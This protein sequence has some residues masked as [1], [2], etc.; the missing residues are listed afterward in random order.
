MNVF[1]GSLFEPKNNGTWESTINRD[2]AHYNI[3]HCKREEDGMAALREIFPN[4]KAD[5]LNFVL[6]STSGVHGS[7]VTIEEVERGICDAVTFLVIHPR[8]CCLRYGNCMPQTKE[9]LEFLKTL[10]ASSLLAVSV[11]GEECEQ[12]K[13]TNPHTAN[14]GPPRDRHTESPN[15]TGEDNEQ[16]SHR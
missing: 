10:R 1:S 13:P 12:R 6:F 15:H 8:I 9:D 7:Y 14:G 2:G 16:D 11:I 4:G 3:F 5:E